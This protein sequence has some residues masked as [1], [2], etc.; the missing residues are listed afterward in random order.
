MAAVLGYANQIDDSTL[1]GGSWEAN[2]PITNLQNKRRLRKA[3]S[4]T[5]SA[6]IEIALPGSITVGV[7]ALCSHNLSNAATVAITCGTFS[8]SETVYPAPV[9]VSPDYAVVVDPDTTATSCTITISDAGNA[10]GYVEVGRVFIGPAFRPSTC[11]DWGFSDGLI[12]AST[13]QESLGGPEYF[14]DLTA[15]RS[16]RGQFSWLT[17]A[18]AAQLR[19]IMRVQDIGYELY[20]VPR[21]DAPPESRGEMWFLGRFAELSDIAYPYLDVHSAP[22]NIRELL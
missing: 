12:S 18:E 5:T 11:V 22:I 1:S 3:R 9:F 10:D 4:T 14:M 13:M 6:T 8:S 2:Y 15:R 16:W 7:I 21:E 20:W 17:T 19:T